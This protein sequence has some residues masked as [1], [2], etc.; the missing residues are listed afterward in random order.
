MAWTGVTFD[1]LTNAI[2][3][4]LSL[5]F[6]HICFPIALDCYIQK[7]QSCTYQGPIRVKQFYVQCI[8]YFYYKLDGTLCL[9]MFYDWYFVHNILTWCMYICLHD[10]HILNI[11][12][13]YKSNWSGIKKIKSHLFTRMINCSTLKY[14]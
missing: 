10:N 9:S 6:H 3:L 2:W 4:G 7:R 13:F 14:Y 8:F 11:T 5:L 1:L 12:S